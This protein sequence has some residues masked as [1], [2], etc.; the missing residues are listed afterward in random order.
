MILEIL[1]NPTQTWSIICVRVN[2]PMFK[3]RERGDENYSLD[4]SL[5][6]SIKLR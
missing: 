6:M 3:S 5:E 1:L 2:K 4:C